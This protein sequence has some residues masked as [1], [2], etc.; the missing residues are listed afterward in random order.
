MTSGIPGSSY[1][2][3]GDTVIRLA[4]WRRLASTGTPVADIAAAIGVSRDALDQ[5]VCRARRHGHPDAI[6]HPN[7]GFQGLRHLYDGRARR[8]RI[9]AR[10][11]NRGATS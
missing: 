7:S 9:H 4:R 8:T 6:L 10:N 2:P 3:R 11:S 5:M 1:Q